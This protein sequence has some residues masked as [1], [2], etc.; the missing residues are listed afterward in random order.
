MPVIG[1]K[2]GR[3]SI[4]TDTAVATTVKTTRA[5]GVLVLEAFD[6]SK[7]ATDTPVFFVTYK[8]TTDP[9]TGIVSITNLVSWKALVNSGANTL[10]NLTVQPGYVDGGNAIGD[11]IECIPTSAWENSL[12]DGIFVGHN[13]DGS[14][15]KAQLQADLGNDG[16]LVDTLNELTNDIVVSGGIWTA[17]VGLN[18][19]MT[20]LV[21]YINGYKN[22]VAAVA[23][24]AF[25]PSKDTYVDVL[26]NTT[27]NDFSLVY[28]EVAVAAAAPALAANSIRIAIVTTSGAAVTA[29]KQYNR[30]FGN[31]IDSLGNVIYPF[32]NSISTTRFQVSDVNQTG[33]HGNFNMAGMAL[34]INLVKPATVIQQVQ[35]RADYQIGAGTAAITPDCDGVFPNA[36]SMV[37]R[38]FSVTSTSNPN[39]TITAEWRWTL[40]AGV[41]TFR[42]FESSSGPIY[43][44]G[45]D[46]WA[47]Y[48]VLY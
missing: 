35:V 39:Q 29:V 14:F 6:L 41:H 2:F 38:A 12:I 42:V 7:F 18:A 19:G 11:F 8:K 46:T 36:P 47:N 13:P 24:R 17:L 31:Y 25:T 37:Q 30:M 48:T 10:T 22:T 33:G 28:T 44:I 20:V 4:P 45:T 16:R 3:A 5:A 21:A 1:D 43:I 27:T 9:V 23:T 34:T 40:P 32:S 15:K 26:H